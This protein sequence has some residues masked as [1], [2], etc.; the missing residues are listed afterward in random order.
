MNDT[1]E[2][3][4]EHAGLV[5]VKTQAIGSGVSSVTVTGAF[6]S[7]FDNYRIIATDITG[8]N[9]VAL[10]MRMG[11]ETGTNYK[12]LGQYQKWSDS[13]IVAYSNTAATYWDSIGRITQDG[14]NRSI[15]DLCSP[16]KTA[17]THGTSDGAGNR[18]FEF[19]VS[20]SLWLNTTD[21]YTSFQMFPNSGTI[22]GGT[23]R[24]Y[25][26]NNG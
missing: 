2:A 9:N 18:N 17:P 22:T 20:L 6:S 3:L 15:L 12:Y 23:I 1:V 16:Y 5:L 10:N 25:G 26:Y 7:T 11:S 24:V 21:S 4:Q 14:S 8:T 13:T 19:V